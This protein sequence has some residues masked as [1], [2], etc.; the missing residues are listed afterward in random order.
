MILLLLCLKLSHCFPL[1]IM[2][3]NFLSLV[4]K[5]HCDHLLTLAPTTLLQQL[6]HCSVWQCYKMPSTYLTYLILPFSASFTLFMCS[7]ALGWCFL[8]LCIRIAM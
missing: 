1:P 3:I 6:M 5:A 7:F 8:T 4:F 2:R